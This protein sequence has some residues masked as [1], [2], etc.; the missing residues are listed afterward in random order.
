MPRFE[1]LNV[2]TIREFDGGW[3]TVTSDLNLSTKFSKTEDNV[4][5]GLSG[6]KQ[7]YTGRY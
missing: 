6:T 3:N 1:G 5:Y 2:S 4:F 7:R